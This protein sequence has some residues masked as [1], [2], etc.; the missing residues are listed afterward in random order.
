MD[1]CPMISKRVLLNAE[2]FGF[3]PSAAIAN[4]FPY[5]RPY[6]SYIGYI[7]NTHSLDLQRSLPYDAIH[8]CD[9]NEEFKR[10]IENYDVFI[11]A[12]DFEKAEI[13]KACGKQIIIYDTLTWYWTNFPSIIAQSDLYITQDFYGVKE[14][15]LKENIHSAAIVPP[16]VKKSDCKRSGENI[17]INLGGLQNPH[18]N[19]QQT[20]QYA[21]LII[22]VLEDIIKAPVY[23]ATSKKIA[24]QLHS[25]LFIIDTFSYAQI[26]QILPQ[27]KYVISTSG[28]GNIYDSAS[29]DIPTLFL[30]AANDSQA[31]QAHY[32]MHDNSI[33]EYVDWHHIH[34]DLTVDYYLSQKDILA[35]ISRNIQLINDTH[36]FKDKFRIL[37]SGA[38]NNLCKQQKS[39]TSQLLNKF[40][41]DGCDIVA[42]KIISYIR[43]LS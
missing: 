43:G 15:L 38:I 25:S 41:C 29:F 11:T 31:I 5:L 9:N 26:K 18:W 4:I 30:P 35:H 22:D 2:E 17:L 21:Q 3:G 42:Q 27:M 10:V 13:A 36:Y 23:V 39:K 7:G 34:D 37:L 40:G 12:L 19:L 33:D 14:R 1:L 32:M 28:L 16:L 6:F 8:A 24:E 20:A